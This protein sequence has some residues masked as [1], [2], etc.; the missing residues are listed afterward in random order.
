MK[1]IVGISGGVDSQSALNWALDNYGP[2]D[3]IALNADPGGNEHPIT[4]D[5]IAWLSANVHPVVSVYPKYRDVW[6]N[7]ATAEKHGVDWNGDMSFAGLAT[8]KGRFPSRKAQFC[9]TFLKLA[10]S[11]RWIDEHVG[12]EF[13]RVS[14]V[15]RDESR[16]RAR[17]RER[18]WDEYFECYTSNPLATWSKDRCFADCLGRGQRVNPLYSMGFSRVG[19]APCINA[20]RADIRAWV[21]R[22]PEMIEKVRGWEAQTGRTF[23]PPMVPGKRINWIDEVVAWA[24]EVPRSRGQLALDVLYTPAVCE[25]VYGLCE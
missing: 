16:D 7:P 12:E 15:R 6:V 19:C 25:S 20:G 1:Y 17:T 18:F 10:P 5:F 14:G 3:V 22:G 21:A 23:F 24:M 11:R 4:T 2:K 13:E 8:V 9:T